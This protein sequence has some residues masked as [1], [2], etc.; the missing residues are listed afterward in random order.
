L[1]AAVFVTDYSMQ[2]SS[3]NINSI[4]DVAADWHLSEKKVSDPR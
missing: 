3:S 1:D 4:G 2:V